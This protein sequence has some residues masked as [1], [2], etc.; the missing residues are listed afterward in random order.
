LL[1]VLILSLLF[2]LINFSNNKGT[3]GEIIRGSDY[4]YE[5]ELR[6]AYYLILEGEYNRSA[7]LA[8]EITRDDPDSAI[9]FHILGLAHARRGLVEEAASAFNKAI[10]LKPEFHMAWFD[11]GV[12]E[13]S[14]GEFVRAL[15]DYNHALEL[16]PDNSEYQQAVD[17][18]REILTGSN[19]WETQLAEYERLFVTGV[20]AVNRGGEV[21]L[22]YAQNIFKALVD[23]RPYDV[24][25]RNMLAM[26]YARQ[27]KLD[28]AEDILLNVVND[29]PGYSDAWFNLGIIHRSL[30]LYE[31][32]LEDF[33]IAWSS[34]NLESL[35]TTV[36]NEIQELNDILDTIDTFHPQPQGEKSDTISTE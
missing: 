26:T 6:D 22:V 25:S 11:L 13:E 27:G 20:E 4:N 14:R 31:T 19:S 36:E 18:I 10:E 8:A 2:G 5:A 32:A 17:R 35:R 21:D 28:V 30:G 15:E 9:A 24:A 3:F 7:A 16:D 1:I 33:R 23:S 34:T 12:V 29:E